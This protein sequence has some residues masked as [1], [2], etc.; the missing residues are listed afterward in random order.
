MRI[1][2]EDL[3]HWHVLY[4]G[5]VGPKGLG[6]EEREAPLR[7][8]EYHVRVSLNDNEIPACGYSAA[9]MA[10]RA[11]VHTAGWPT[12]GFA[13]RRAHSQEVFKATIGA[14]YQSSD[15]LVPRLRNA[16]WTCG[17]ADEFARTPVRRIRPWVETLIL[18][19]CLGAVE[20][21]E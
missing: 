17:Q 10:A 9:L 13:L 12:V 4:D 21:L 5:L 15:T 1:T 18:A 2:V 20:Q 7:V 14:D 6:P 8:I 3:P 19:H 11:L 16:L